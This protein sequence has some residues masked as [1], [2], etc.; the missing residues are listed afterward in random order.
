MGVRIRRK[1]QANE[2]GIDNMERAAVLRLERK[3]VGRRRGARD[4]CSPPGAEGQGKVISSLQFQSQAL[5]DSIGSN[6]K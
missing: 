4:L 1:G 6:R 3:K 2:G 5:A